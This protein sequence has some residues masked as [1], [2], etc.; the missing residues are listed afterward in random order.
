MFLDVIDDRACWLHPR[1]RGGCS[2]PVLNR[3][4]HCPPRSWRGSVGAWAAAG[5]PA[6]PL[7]LATAWPRRPALGCDCCE[8]RS[9]ARRISPRRLQLLAT[10]LAT[11]PASLPA[12]LDGRFGGGGGIICF[13][14]S[15]DGLPFSLGSRCGRCEAGD[16][17]GV[18]V[19]VAYGSY[20]LPSGIEVA[21]VVCVPFLWL[22]LDA[23]LGPICGAGTSAPTS[24]RRAQA[25]CGIYML[26]TTRRL[27]MP[28]GRRPLQLNA[29]D[30]GEAGERAAGIGVHLSHPASK[31]RRLARSP[32]VCGQSEQRDQVGLRRRARRCDGKHP[33][34]L[35]GYGRGEAGERAAGLDLHNSCRASKSWQLARARSAS[36]ECDS[37]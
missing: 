30:R 21:F 10:L 19:G 24:A 28:N 23:F 27:E 12:R 32:C 31:S 14:D 16:A 29:Y 22:N 35:D 7:G 13:A 9:I 4:P 33:L 26:P 18:E 3:S 37:C 1:Q 11:L 25:V 20:A 17:C 6:P 2:R 15:G 8:A 36:L 5:A 34:R